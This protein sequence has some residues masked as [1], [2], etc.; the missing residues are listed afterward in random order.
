MFLTEKIFLFF[1]EAQVPF[2]EVVVDFTVEEWVLLDPAQRALHQEVT[3]EN[4]ASLAFVGKSHFGW[5]DSYVE[6]RKK[7]VAVFLTILSHLAVGP[8][9]LHCAY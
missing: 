9:C 4:Y 3:E 2:E 8:A 5:T 6:D 7:Y 1:F